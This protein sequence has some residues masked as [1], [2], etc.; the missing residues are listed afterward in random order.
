[1]RSPT[2]PG[3]LARSERIWQ[4]F[5]WLRE[6]PAASSAAPASASPSCGCSRSCMAAQHGSNAHCGGARFVVGSPAPGRTP[7]TLRRS[8][9]RVLVVEDNADLAFGLRNNLEIEGY[10]VDVAADGPPGL[11]A[12]AAS[13]ADLVVL[14]LMLPGIDGYRVLRQLRDDG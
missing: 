2:G 11:A 10:A 14:D 3:M 7:A 5:N 13:T 12:R 4:P 6:A 8:M 9:T 1:M